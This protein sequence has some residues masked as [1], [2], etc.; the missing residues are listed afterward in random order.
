MVLEVCD[1]GSGIPKRDLKR[2]FEPFFTTK[3]SRGG[4]GLGL[5]IC[6]SIVNEHA[7]IIRVNSKV[8]RGTTFSIFLK[9]QKEG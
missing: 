4:I 3:T 7:G 2:L 9:A 5:E 8:G 1:T 6:L